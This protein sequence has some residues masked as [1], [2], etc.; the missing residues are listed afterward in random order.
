LQGRHEAVEDEELDC[1][2]GVASGALSCRRSSDG[3]AA[4]LAPTPVFFGRGARRWRG[5][6]GWRA[7]SVAALA[8]ARAAATVASDSAPATTAR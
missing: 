2:Q 1:V 4:A 8:R 5:G 3:V 7:R 6:P